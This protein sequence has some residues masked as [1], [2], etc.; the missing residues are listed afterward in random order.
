[1]RV[2]LN[3]FHPRLPESRVNRAWA[4]AAAQA[5]IPVRDLFDLYPHGKIDVE[6][7]QRV[8]EECDRIVFQHPFHWYSAPALMKQWLDEVLTYGWAYGGP[9]RLTGKRWRSAISVGGRQEEY[10]PQGNRRYSVEEF[11]RPYERTAA[12]CRMEW[13]TPFL[14][15]G[16]G[17]VD[18]AA[19]AASCNDFVSALLQ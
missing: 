7:E 19:I 13:E 18:E 1:M 6:A 9:D 5:G 11:L 2:V 17:Y 10:T 15:Y 16:S 8:C 14:F 12:F 3:V 4:T